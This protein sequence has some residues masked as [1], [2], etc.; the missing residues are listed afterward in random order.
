MKIFQLK[1]QERS[2]LRGKGHRSNLG[3]YLDKIM[4][5]GFSLIIVSEPRS[6]PESPPYTG[7]AQQDQ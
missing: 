5:P 3:S 1:S 4:D 7:L 2:G 6:W